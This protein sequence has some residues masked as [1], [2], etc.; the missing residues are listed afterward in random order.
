MNFVRDIKE[1][2]IFLSVKV[3]KTTSRIKRNAHPLTVQRLRPAME[4]VPPVCQI[5]STS[6]AKFSGVTSHHFLAFLNFFHDMCTIL[7]Y[8]P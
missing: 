2:R 8:L 6:D 3:R 1:C 7:S 4:M 5:Y